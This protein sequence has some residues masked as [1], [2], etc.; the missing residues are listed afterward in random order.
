M[1][2]RTSTKSSS[3]SSRAE[4]RER[5]HGVPPGRPVAHRG[6]RVAAHR[7]RRPA[8]QARGRRRRRKSG[9]RERRRRR[10]CPTACMRQDSDR[11][12][13]RMGVH[14]TREHAAHADRKFDAWLMSPCGIAIDPQASRTCQPPPLRCS[15]FQETL[16]GCCLLASGGSQAREAAAR[17]CA[18]PHTS[19]LFVLAQFFSWHSPFRYRL[20]RNL[21]RS[22]QFL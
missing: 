13:L 14:L 15:R 4:L 3:T 8:R 11:H 22:R 16:Y 12:S 18:R 21:S 7:S 20:C 1:A 9:M 17:N 19:T 2:N 6:G 5:S 10:V